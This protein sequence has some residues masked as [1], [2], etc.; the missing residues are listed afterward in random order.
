MI[1][2]MFLARRANESCST[3]T[4]VTI[5]PAIQKTILQKRLLS[6]SSCLVLETQDRGQGQDCLCLHPR[7]C[8][9]KR[10]VSISTLGARAS[11]RSSRGAPTT[12]CVSRPPRTFLVYEPLGLAPLPTYLLPRF[13]TRSDQPRETHRIRQRDLAF[14]TR[15]RNGGPF[16]SPRVL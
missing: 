13:Q 15:L 10:R 8:R 3:T 4:P 11:N 2:S 14:L 7:W 5:R 6:P 16:R 9:A 12:V 1:F